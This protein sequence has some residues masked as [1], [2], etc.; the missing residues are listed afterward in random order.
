VNVPVAAPA[1]A[2]P[3]PGANQIEAN[4]PVFRGRVKPGATQAEFALS[5]EFVVRWTVP[6]DTNTSQ[7]KTLSPVQL[8]PGSYTY[9]I[10]DAFEGKFVVN[11]D[12]E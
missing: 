4:R 12:A 7:Y 9:Y 3:A 10:N 1:A 5:P 6:V 2:T 8:P 11:A